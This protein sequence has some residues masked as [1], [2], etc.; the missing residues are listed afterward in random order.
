LIT[1]DDERNQHGIVAVQSGQTN[2]GNVQVDMQNSSDNN[3]QLSASLPLAGQ[4]QSAVASSSSMDAEQIKQH[5]PQTDG[6]NDMLTLIPI[7]QAWSHIRHQSGLFSY[8]DLPHFN[9]IRQATFR[10][11]RF[12]CPFCNVD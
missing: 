6:T 11:G 1:S 5:H 2:D 4:M 8:P 9:I 10:D 12:V 7:P 3:Q